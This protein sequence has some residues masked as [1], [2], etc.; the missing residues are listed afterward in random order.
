LDST[1]GTWV[2]GTRIAA[3]EPVRVKDGDR[4]AVGRLSVLTINVPPVEAG[5]AGNAGTS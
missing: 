2:N 1:N 4:I 3:G 5:K